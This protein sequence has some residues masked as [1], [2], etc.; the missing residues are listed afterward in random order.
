MIRQELKQSSLNSDL[1]LSGE[2]FSFGIPVNTGLAMSA[3]LK[4]LE[5][6]FVIVVYLVIFYI[7][8]DLMF[9]AHKSISYNMGAITQSYLIGFIFVGI[10]LFEIFRILKGLRGTKA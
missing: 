3:K 9:R 1:V 2:G 10:S 6:I 5:T 8:A 7:G 4:T